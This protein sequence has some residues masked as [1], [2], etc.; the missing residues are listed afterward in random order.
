[1]ISKYLCKENHFVF[2]VYC[3]PWLGRESR[4]RR[5]RWC[6]ERRRWRKETFQKVVYTDEVQ[7]Q[8]GSGT[9]WRRKV[10]RKPGP[11]FAYKAQNFQPTFIGELL[12]VG[13]WAAFSYGNHT[14]LIPL[15]KWTENER[16][17][18]KDQLGFNSNQYVHEILVPHLLPFYVK[19]EGLGGGC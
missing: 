1:M 14:P 13:F 18:E 15:C 6:R 11:Q 16:K 4:K 7:L 2:L 19:C 12:S 5:K 10:G 3:K 8:V 17:S 9:G